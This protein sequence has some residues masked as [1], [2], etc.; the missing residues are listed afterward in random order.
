MIE[1]LLKIL[2]LP[3]ESDSDN[4]RYADYCRNFNSRNNEC[5]IYDSDKKTKCYYP[6]ELDRR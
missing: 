6:S 3:E 2:N 5:R 4:C 1:K